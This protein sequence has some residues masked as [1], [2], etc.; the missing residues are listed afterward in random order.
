MALGLWLIVSPWTIAHNMASAD[1][2]L[3]VTVAAMWALH[4]IGILVTILALAALS[5]FADWKEWINV[6][7][8]ACLLISPFVLGFTGS[9]GLEWNAFICGALIVG[10]S[11]WSLAGGPGPKI[12]A[13]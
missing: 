1:N 2:P 11:L 8:G 9:A 6:V 3:G 10:F 13:H 5:G 4:G 7:L 12:V